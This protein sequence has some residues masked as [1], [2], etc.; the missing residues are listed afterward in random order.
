ML[1][2][3]SYQKLKKHQ[4]E[5]AAR[6]SA[7]TSPLPASS[8][9]SQPQDVALPLTPEVAT[10]VSSAPESPAPAHE[11][12]HNIPRKPLPVLTKE[13]ED[14]LRGY[15]GY[16]DAVEDRPPLPVRPA[17]DDLHVAGDST[18]NDQQVV[19]HEG[20]ENH[21]YA[22]GIVGGIKQRLGKGKGKEKETTVED[23][24]E[25][26]KEGTSKFGFIGRT[27]SKKVSTSTTILM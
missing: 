4:A 17:V 16:G 24:V 6:E 3:F 11:Q 26:K 2:Y 23:E 7:A 21:G 8:S 20:K 1:E 18:G 5:K 22:A 9:T 15:V 27:F 25:V 14:F 10:P 13:D 12:A 19:A